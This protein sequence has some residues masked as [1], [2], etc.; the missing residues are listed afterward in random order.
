MEFKLTRGKEAL[1][2][3]CQAGIPDS[4]FR[5]ANGAIYV[6]MNWERLILFGSDAQ[7]RRFDRFRQAYIQ[8][9]LKAHTL[10]EYECDTRIIGSKSPKSDVDINL[11]CETNLD[12]VYR[13]IHDDH[14]RR[15]PGQS[16]SD[17]F[18]TNIY[19]TIYHYINPTCDTT[20]EI[21]LA[22]YPRRVS[23]VEQRRW[24]FVRI[25]ESLGHLAPGQR[26]RVLDAFPPAYRAL[27]NQSQ[28]QLARARRAYKH[29]DYG[30]HVARYHDLLK[31]T[32]PK[33]APHDIADAFSVAS[34]GEIDSYRSVGAIL[35]IVEKLPSLPHSLLY[36]S[37]YDNIGFIYAIL[38]VKTLCFKQQTL[39]H[40]VKV[41]KYINRITDA[42]R[43]MVEPDA[44]LIAID[45]LSET[46]NRK[47]KEMAAIAD[48]EPHVDRLLGL[49]G[50]A[51]HSRVDF[52]IKWTDFIVK[53]MPRDPLIHS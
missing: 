29:H 52:L 42:I 3:Q 31:Q 25:A 32:A 33:A 50:V 8:Q 38:C 39:V 22:C 45:Q 47:R 30:Y 49:L 51:D 34:W 14:A 5:T 10:P 28:R 19:S 1:F 36:D 12:A 18:D 24:S 48:L 6:Q 4:A 26:Q 46:I 2:R 23:N 41:C 44:V 13:A 11:Y 20:H 21:L 27:Y 16:L 53:A 7:I 37:I 43:R 40:F 35:H 9:L 15:Y 17:L